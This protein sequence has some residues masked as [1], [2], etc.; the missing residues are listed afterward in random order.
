M[1]HSAVMRVLESVRISQLY[2]AIDTS[3]HSKIRNSLLCFILRMG[4]EG[5]FE[6]DLRKYL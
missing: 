3:R 2:R 6:Q 5:N 1:D 4:G